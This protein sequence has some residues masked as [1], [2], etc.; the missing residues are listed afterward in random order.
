MG[1]VELILFGIDHIR[2]P[3]SEVSVDEGTVLR[4]ELE[5][6]IEGNKQC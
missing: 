1:Q 5:A 6:C 4:F 3:G 2:E